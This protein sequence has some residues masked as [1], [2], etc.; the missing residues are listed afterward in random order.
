MSSRLCIAGL[1]GQTDRHTVQDQM[2]TFGRQ[3]INFFGQQ[4]T[5][6]RRRHCF[7]PRP[8][9]GKKFDNGGTLD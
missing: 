8:K 4:P 6:A 2:R 9:L 3:E 1:R 5:L 7:Q